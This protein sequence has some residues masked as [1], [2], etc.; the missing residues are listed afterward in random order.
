MNL[1]KPEPIVGGSGPDSDVVVSSR[2]RLARNIAGF[3][4]VNKASDPQR[5]EILN[6]VRR[7]RFPEKTASDM[8]WVDMMQATPHDR[9][10]L[11][12]RHLISKQFA[13]E[14]SPRGVAITSD[15]TISIMV[16]EEDHLRIQSM[17]S[18]FGLQDAFG[19]ID[20][21]DR[22]LAESMDFAFDERW[23]YL[24]ACP[25]NVGCGIRLSVMLHL[26]A[27]RM[28]TAPTSVITPYGQWSHLG[29]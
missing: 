21:F 14:S 26:P 11:V 25:T 20:E 5:H 23:G 3:P 12:E 9:Q 8:I 29:V 2:V 13:D 6:M 27:I 28:S 24:T 1:N 17:V 18:G 4:F 7:C 16:N 10:L 19:S 22:Q 15:E